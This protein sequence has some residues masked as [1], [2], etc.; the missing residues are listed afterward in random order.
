LVVAGVEHRTARQCERVAQR[1]VDLHLHEA[2]RAEIPVRGRDQRPNAQRAGHRV[3]DRIDPRDLGGELPARLRRH[4]D[5]HRLPRL[6]ERRFVLVHLR[7]DPHRIAGQQELDRVT[8]RTRQVADLLVGETLLPQPQIRAAH[9]RIAAGARL[10]AGVRIEDAARPSG[11]TV[12]DERAIEVR[13]VRDATDRPHVHGQGPHRHAL[14]RD[15]DQL[16]AFGGERERGMTGDR[17][18]G[19]AF[20]LVLV[21]RQVVHPHL[22]LGG[23]RRDDVRTHR[24]AIELHLPLAR[25]CALDVRRARS[26]RGAPILVHVL[27]LHPADRAESGMV[28]HDLRMHRALIRRLRYAGRRRTA[29]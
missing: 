9:E 4:G 13:I 5:R 29:A 3:E 1:D 15:A 2:F 8:T 27:Q 20:V 22:V 14:A 11:L 28:G 6:N 18:A 24:V 26:A 19:A 23:L 10:G 25:R 12:V 21:H 7:V 16:L 17:M